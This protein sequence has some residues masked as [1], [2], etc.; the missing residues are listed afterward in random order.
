M[1]GERL[2]AGLKKLHL[3]LLVLVFVM[4]L[5]RLKVIVLNVI[6][7]DDIIHNGCVDCYGGGNLRGFDCRSL[8]E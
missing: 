5:A 6:D 8:P 1:K 4:F 7:N 3:V 2:V